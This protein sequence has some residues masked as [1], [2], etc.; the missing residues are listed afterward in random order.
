LFQGFHPWL[1]TAA[2]PRLTHDNVLGDPAEWKLVVVTPS[3]L[4]ETPV[5]FKL[6]NIPLP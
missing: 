3:K 2:A 1:M 5:K 4:V 6:E